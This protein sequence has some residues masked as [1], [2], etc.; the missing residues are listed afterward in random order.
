M[1]S[2]NSQSRA[3]GFTLLE[4]LVAV[5]VFAIFSALAYGSLTR[6]LESRDRIEAER[7]FWRDLSLAFTQIEDDLSM[8][9]SRTVRDVYGNPLPAFRGQPVDPRPQGEPS[10]E[11]TRGGLFVLGDSRR[12][13]LQRTGYR[14]QDDKLVRLVWP[15]LD[16]P[17]QIEPQLAVLLENVS[18]LQV[19]FYVAGAGWVNQWPQPNAPLVGL[20]AAVELTLTIEGR[21]QV[22]RILRVNG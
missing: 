11:F 4:V 7:V 18:E 9:R 14:L 15:A 21:G 6:L 3:R 8:A 2:I 10:L 22:Q 1:R 20:P 13:D 17:T 16:Q 5:G 19:R 12:S